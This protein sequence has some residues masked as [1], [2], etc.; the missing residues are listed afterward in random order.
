MHNCGYDGENP[1]DWSWADG[2]G[3]RCTCVKYTCAWVAVGCMGLHKEIVWDSHEQ[4]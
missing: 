2:H 1:R 3:H 4:V